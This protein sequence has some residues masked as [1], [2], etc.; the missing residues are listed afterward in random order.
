MP[1]IMGRYLVK[2]A[3]FCCSLSILGGYCV[4]CFDKRLAG[5]PL[6]RMLSA[7]AQQ[8]DGGRVRPFGS[9]LTSIRGLSIFDMSFNDECHLQRWSFGR[10]RAIVAY[11]Q[12]CLLWRRI[13]PAITLSYRSCGSSAR[14]SLYPFTLHLPALALLRARG[15]GC[16]PVLM[17]NEVNSLLGLK[18]YCNSALTL[19]IYP[20]RSICQCHLHTS[21]DQYG[22][23]SF[24]RGYNTG[25]CLIVDS[26]IRSEQLVN[27]LLRWT[28]YI[29]FW[30]GLGLH[31][32]FTTYRDATLHVRR[33][34]RCGMGNY[35][36]PIEYHGAGH[37]CRLCG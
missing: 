2:L 6:Y 23:L 33:D 10:L 1:L 24:S 18:M 3:R 25:C 7:N 9:L 4:D 34:C 35:R 31:R 19:G 13:V 29:R 14:Q 28:L 21:F 36:V 17:G 5:T 37:T 32:I 11:F 12:V 8:L 26:H 15:A 27:P 30:G 16:A 20:H 22:L